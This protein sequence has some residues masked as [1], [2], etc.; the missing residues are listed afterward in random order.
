MAEVVPFYMSTRN[1]W[2]ETLTQ[3]CAGQL[4]ISAEIDTKNDSKTDGYKWLTVDTIRQKHPFTRSI[5]EPMEVY[6]TLLQGV[7]L[8]S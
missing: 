1:K 5:T 7:I 8:A 4:L 2:T 3:E 6:A